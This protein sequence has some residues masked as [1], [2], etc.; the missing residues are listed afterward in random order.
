MVQTYFDAVSHYEKVIQL[1]VAGIGLDF[2]HGKDENLS[3]LQKHGFP[4]NKVLGAG[5]I[6]GR[7]I[8]RANLSVVESSFSEILSVSPTANIWLQP[9][10]SLLQ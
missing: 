9:S 1:P 6:D 7:N 8:W 2:V 10:S 3:S 4:S 5:I